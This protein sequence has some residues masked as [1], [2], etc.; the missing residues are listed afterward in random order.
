MAGATSTQ[1]LFMPGGAL[2]VFHCPADTGW[3][4][5]HYVEERLYHVLAFARNPVWIQFGTRDPII[6]DQTRVMLHRIG[7]PYRR[8]SVDGRPDHCRFI[9]I[10]DATAR[11][12]A[13]EIL[14]RAADAETVS[15]GSPY[16]EVTSAAFLR[17]KTSI[18]AA[19]RD[20]D[21]WRGAEATYAM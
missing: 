19:V 2:G 5:G 13:G 18:A 16:I 8:T 10:D 7:Q 6:A 21:G 12:I 9:A 20:S 1:D 3:N 15:F 14:P 17:F 11:G 4:W